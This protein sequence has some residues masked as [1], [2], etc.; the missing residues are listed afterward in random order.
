MEH[1]T[2]HTPRGQVT[3]G[4][5]FEQTLDHVEKMW[6]PPD[7]EL[8]AK[9]RRGLE[10]GRY[11]LDL[12]FLIEDIR[13]DF[14]IL[15]YCLK[16]L[17]GI[18]GENKDFANDPFLILRNAGLQRLKR[19]LLVDPSKISQHSL[20]RIEDFQGDRLKEVLLSA[21]TVEALSKQSGVNPEV[22]FSAAVLRQL[23]LV[24]IAWNY[25]KIYSKALTKQ[26]TTKSIDLILSEMLGFSPRLLAFALIRRWGL[27]E[28]LVP[29]KTISH[30]AKQL[31]E[32]PM[33]ARLDK[34]CRIGEA[35]AR[36]NN[37]D[38]YPSAEHDWE[39]AR[40]EIVS[41]LGDSG[42]SKIK[43]HVK[44]NAENYT[45]ALP[46]VFEEVTNIEAE[47]SLARIHQERILGKNPFL[48]GCS[49]EFQSKMRPVYDSMVENE[50]SQ[51][52][53]KILVQEIIPFTGFSGGAIYVFD[54]GIT[55]LVPQLKLGEIRRSKLQPLNVLSS[56]MFVDPVVSAFQCTAPLI[57]TF[58]PDNSTVMS[59]VAGSLGNDERAGVIYLEIPRYLLNA[60]DTLALTYFKAFRQAF[61][62]CLRLR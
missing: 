41:I 33:V 43:E 7:I 2:P 12:D 24:L 14:S 53:I 13:S 3:D 46:K 60:L 42:L 58:Q 25:P 56:G 59:F 50:I 22:G 8:L 26:N 37:A 31:T 57:G 61:N 54:P 47:A 27:S 5:R 28:E 1:N 32:M 34:L 20:N 39:E 38:V 44:R 52:G 21:S 30:S 11:D 10:E 17:A 6:F 23:G 4:T 51:K 48:K 62:D 40:T 18:I 15:T 9:I 35:L 29:F 16:E 55:T 36:A 45:S 49:L 19:I